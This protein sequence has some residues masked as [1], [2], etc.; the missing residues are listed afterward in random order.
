[1]LLHNKI[2]VTRANNFSRRFVLNAVAIAALGFSL[3]VAHSATAQEI[4]LGIIDTLE[5]NAAYVGIACEAGVKIAVD[6][7]NKDPEKYLGSKSRSIVADTRNGGTTLTQA[8]ALARE[9]AGD[10]K[11]L[12]MLGPSLTPQA[13][14]LGPFAQQSK[15]P[16]LI[17]NSP[18]SDLTAP[19]NYVLAQGQ[20]GVKLAEDVVRAYLK[21]HPNTKRAGVL[22]TTDNQAIIVSGEAAEKAFKAGGAEV[23]TFAVPFASLDYANAIDAMKKAN[24]EVIYMGPPAAAVTAA[25]QQ[26]RRV[27]F[28][29]S[30]LGYGNMASPTVIENGGEAID[31]SLIATDYDPNLPGALNAGFIEAFKKATGNPPDTYGAHGFNAIMLVASAIKSI[32]GEVTRDKFVEALAK[33][34]IESVL[35]NGMFSFAPDRTVGAPAALLQ[36]VGKDLKSYKP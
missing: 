5:G 23:T 32:S 24:V 21:T 12:A 13:I 11:Y 30:Y 20:S 10:P 18:G 16:L 34:K 26:A 29:P 14:A 7:I 27:N 1:M 22:S 19:G 36:I 35:A 15:F 6:V 28:K 33:V 4:K 31:G 17:M 9:F 2:N 3:T 25:V 8:L